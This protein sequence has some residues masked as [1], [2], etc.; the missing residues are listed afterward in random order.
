M[1]CQRRPLRRC[2]QR[3]VCARHL[4]QPRQHGVYQLPRGQRLPGDDVE[5]CSLRVPRGLVVSGQVRGVHA[6]FTWH[7]LCGIPRDADP[8]PERRL[9]GLRSR[10][11]YILP[12]RLQLPRPD[13]CR[14]GALRTRL[15]RSRPLVG[16]LHESCLCRLHHWQLLSRHGHR[17]A[18]G[19]CGGDLLRLCWGG[20]LHDMS[21]RVQLF[22]AHEQPAVSSIR[23]WPPCFALPHSSFPTPSQNRVR[24]RD[25]LDA[26]PRGVPPV[27][28]RLLLCC[29]VDVAGS[30]ALHHRWLLLRGRRLHPL[31][32]R[33]AR[34]CVAGDGRRGRLRTLSR[35]VGLCA[36]RQPR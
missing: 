31:R 25:V 6:V 9:L 19:V 35:G 36:R 15:V 11:L 23:E 8:V 2:Q 20:L 18:D 28:R 24:R 21:R 26:G 5:R 10:R 29:R 22:V 33:L 4:R 30:A 13:L 3:R 12:R 34:L 14:C 16:G 1:C 17:Y 7:I 32:G 27:H